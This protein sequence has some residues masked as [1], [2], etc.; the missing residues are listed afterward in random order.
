MLAFPRIA[1][2]GWSAPQSGRRRWVVVPLASMELWA[3]RYCCGSSPCR[4]ST[5]R[6]SQLFRSSGVCDPTPLSSIGR[7]R[8]DPRTPDRAV[9]C[10]W[11]RC[12]GASS[13]SRQCREVVSVRDAVSPPTSSAVRWCECPHK[14]ASTSMSAL[15]VSPRCARQGKC[16]QPHGRRPSGRGAQGR[17]GGGPIV[18]RELSLGFVV[19]GRG[20]RHPAAAP[21]HEGARVSHSAVS[22]RAP[23]LATAHC[24]R[25][26]ACRATGRL[27]RGRRCR[28]LAFVLTPGRADGSPQFVVVLEKAKA[29]S[30]CRNGICERG[31]GNGPGPRRE[32]PWRTVCNRGG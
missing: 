23:A 6:R 16:G 27:E 15:P 9:A 11:G 10:C 17:W 31:V 26:A 21:R 7:G 14:R 30:S 18:R 19:A 29:T 32:W 22:R 2:A 4:D 20:L 8:R 28:L 5:D 13:V 12:Q 3:G 25:A 1:V 24:C